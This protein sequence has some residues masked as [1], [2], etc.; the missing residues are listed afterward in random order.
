MLRRSQKHFGAAHRTFAQ[1]QNV[2]GGEF[3]GFAIDRARL[4]DIGMAQIADDRIV[5]DRRLPAGRRT[6]RLE[7]RG[8]EDPLRRSLRSRAA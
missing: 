6:K 3:F 5:V 2:A 4:R 1:R 8:E 7:L